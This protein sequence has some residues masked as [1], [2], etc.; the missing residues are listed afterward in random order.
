[1]LSVKV[2]LLFKLTLCVPHPIEK[3]IHE[4]IARVLREPS[5]EDVDVVVVFERGHGD[6]ALRDWLPVAKTGLGLYAIW[7]KIHFGLLAGLA[8]LGAVGCSS[9]SHVVVG[10]ARPPISPDDVRLYLH[11]PTKYE[12]VALLDASSKN[13]WAVTDQGKT[14][15]VIERLKKQAA[16]LGANGVLISGLSNQSAGSVSVGSATANSYGHTATAFGTGFSA[17]IMLK[18]ASGMAIFVIQE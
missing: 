2:R 11:P 7:M 17:P 16:A 4:W 9:S 14:D 1:V 3:A 13:S 18:E 12:E 6:Q 8:I 10:R 5:S 15:K